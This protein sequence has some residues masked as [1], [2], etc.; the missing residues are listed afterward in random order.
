MTCCCLHHP[1]CCPGSSVLPRTSTGSSGIALSRTPAL[2]AVQSA[3]DGSNQ[4][5]AAEAAVTAAVAAGRPPPLPTLHSR[6]P[7]TSSGA[8]A[9]TADAGPGVRGQ[10][11]PAGADPVIFASSAAVDAAGPP[12]LPQVARSESAKQYP[13]SF[14][15]RLSLDSRGDPLDSSSERRASLESG[16]SDDEYIELEHL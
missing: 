16:A 10:V 15:P 1:P 11:A 6:H 14:V 5:A 13:L 2:R 9:A 8:A 12:A 7:R 3:G 4:A